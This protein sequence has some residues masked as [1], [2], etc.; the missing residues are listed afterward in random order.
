MTNGGSPYT[1]PTGTSVTVVAEALLAGIISPVASP[2]LSL[3]LRK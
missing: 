1:V 2:G 3:Q